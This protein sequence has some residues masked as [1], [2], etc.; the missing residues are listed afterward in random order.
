MCLYLSLHKHDRHTI[1]QFRGALDQ[2]FI[3]C[4]MIQS[5]VGK[6]IILCH[7]EVVIGYWHNSYP[8]RKLRA[9]EHGQI[10]INLSVALIGLYVFFLLGG[11]VTT[12][13]G[14]CGLTSALIQYCFLVFFAWTA[15][16]A[17]Y[18]Y[19]KFVRVLNKPIPHFI[20]ISTLVAW[21]KLL[22]CVANYSLVLPH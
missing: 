8:H 21:G 11:H 18:L 9:S 15:V 16:E 7:A 5:S 3:T 22:V 6:A 10:L 20:V 12:V 19:Q 1:K 17:A 14:L 13:T 2:N 4:I